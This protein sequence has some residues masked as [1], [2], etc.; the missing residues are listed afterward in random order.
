LCAWRCASSTRTP[1]SSTA[2]ACSGATGGGSDSHC[3][4]T[5]WRSFIP[6]MPMSRSRTPSVRASARAAST[7]VVP[8]FSIRTNT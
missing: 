6:A 1:G 5:A 8:R 3:R 2:S 7:V 4:V